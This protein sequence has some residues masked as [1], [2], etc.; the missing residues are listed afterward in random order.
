MTGGIDSLGGDLDLFDRRYRIEEAA[1]RFDGSLD[2]TLQVRIT[3]DFPDV[4]TITL[5][6]GRLSKPELV[7]SSDP[8]TYSQS[9]LLGFLLGGEP[10]GDPN[11]GGARDK[12]TGAGE[13][14]IAGKISGYVRKALPFDIDVIRYEVASVS[15]SAAI[16]VG[17]WL[18]HSLFFAFRQHLDARPDENTGEGTLEYFLTKRIEIEGTAGDRGYDGVDV[19][20]RKR[21]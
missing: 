4:T 2:P 20:W 1:V 15:S 13:S 9:E 14:F 12:L 18:T 21:F 11:A 5:V 17:S 16:T 3:H 7:L 19:L 8:G 6:G 10:G